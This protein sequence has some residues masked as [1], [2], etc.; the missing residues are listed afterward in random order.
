VSVT[1]RTKVAGV[2]G[3][4]VRHSLSPI[5]HN[6]AFAAHGDDWTYCAFEVDPLHAAAAVD[7]MRM[8]GIAGLSVTMPHKEMVIPSLD[9]V[10][11]SATLVRA[12]NTVVRTDDGRLV[13]HN[14]DG[15]G[16]VDAL[17]AAGADLSCVAVVGAGA[18]A[19]A[20]IAALAAA[21]AQVC[22]A[23]RTAPRLAVAVAVGNAVRAGSTKAIEISQVGE[24]QTVVNATPL[25]MAGIAVDESPFDTSRLTSR[26]CVLDAVYHPLET[27]LV[28][29]ARSRG[30]RVVDGLDMLCAQAARQQRLWLGRLPDVALMRR[31][32]L[33][34][35]AKPQQ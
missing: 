22:V 29:E 11:A 25:G 5:I 20:V 35:L 34:E 10:D 4:P 14:T 26:H 31:A 23:N 21:D 2:I 27:R 9:V 30:A 1:A 24:C 18:T 17:T 12:V 33:A 28:R 19:R 8:L 7:A 3:S 16:C 6:A 13:G 32:A 15:V